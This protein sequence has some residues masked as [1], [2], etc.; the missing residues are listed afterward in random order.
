MVVGSATLS[1]AE[2]PDIS[3]VPKDLTTP[4]MTVGEPAP[5]RRVKQTS[6]G[7]E[8]T[9]VYHTLHLPTD[10]R[11]G[12]RFPI[13]VEY[14]GNGPYRNGFGD[15][16]TGK[17]E[18]CNLGYGISGGK[19]FLWICMPFV[20]TETMANQTQWWGDVAATVDYCRT[21]VRRVCETYGG[22]SSSV[23]LTGF[24]RGAIACN[25]IG[26]HDDEIARLWLAFI[27]H[28][29]YDGVKDWAYPGADRASALR[30]LKRLKGRASFVSHEG[31]VE[32]TRRYLA[33][34]GVKAPFT[35]QVLPYRNHRDDWVL[36]D[37]PERGR[38]RAWLGA[39]LRD[40]PGRCD[41]ATK[42]T[43]CD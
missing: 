2:L 41:S 10:W 1:A 25:Y 9:R 8:G 26:L 28:S 43:A 37:I 6:P 17:V 23:I 4:P 14:P 15:V 20:N 19:G 21:T 36:R 29:H 12:E 5:G 7:Y 33:A 3:T 16:C 30:R 34:T 32:E 11:R 18:Y 31:S 42:P 35:F 27:P 39:V 38:L 40:R 24:S 13:L 22:D